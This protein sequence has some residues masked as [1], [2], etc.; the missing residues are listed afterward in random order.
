MRIVNDRSASRQAQKWLSQPTSRGWARG[1][2]ARHS[3]PSSNAASCG[4][5]SAMRPVDVADG[6][7]N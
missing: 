4:A 1:T 3:H 7:A 6:Q 5:E 2:G